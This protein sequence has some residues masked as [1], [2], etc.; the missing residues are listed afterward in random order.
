MPSSFM[1]SHADAPRPRRI[2]PRGFSLVEVILAL[3]IMGLAIIS[4][5]GLIGPTLGD[6]KKA[7]EIN[8][9]TGC[10]EKMNTILEMAPFWDPHANDNPNLKNESVYQWVYLSNSDSPTVFLFYDEIPVP[11]GGKSQ[12]MTP[13]QRVVRFNQ[14]HVELNTPLQAMAVVK[15]YTDDPTVPQLPLYRKMEDFV[16]AAAENRVYGPVIAMTLSV[17]PLM[18]NFP[19]VTNNNGELESTWYQDPP[20]QGL[21]PR[22][23]GM[24]TDP[25]G[26][27]GKVYPEG[28][29]PIYVQAFSVST[30]NIFS[31]QDTNKFDQ[32]LFNNL[33]LSNRLFTYTT[34]KLR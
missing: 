34:A 12:D 4:I 31:V 10:I 28:Y 9:G 27:Q 18:K 6:V 14:N 13:L 24:T 15:N 26:V 23:Q 21:F 22:Q 30:T 19:S 25:S 7:Q 1:P 16:K 5:L 3:G 2:C 29:L 20:N 32:A 33:T 11:T 8:V 17:S